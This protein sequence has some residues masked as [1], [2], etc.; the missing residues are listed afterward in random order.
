MIRRAWGFAVAAGL[1]VLAFSAM[2]LAAAPVTPRI[3]TFDIRKPNGGTFVVAK[4]GERQRKAQFA[5]SAPAKCIYGNGEVSSQYKGAGFVERK[6]IPIRNGAL[7]FDRTASGPAAGGL[8]TLTTHG[9]ISVEF[10]TAMKLVGTM[11]VV[12]K[13][14]PA[15]G[16]QEGTP[17]FPGGT[18]SCK[19]GKVA[20]IATYR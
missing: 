6:F 2:A 11:T 18:M 10:K 5:V 7:K 8:L 3:G 13:Y 16:S 19:T 20:F 17:V 15:E 9:K 4:S 12:S 1:A 14:V